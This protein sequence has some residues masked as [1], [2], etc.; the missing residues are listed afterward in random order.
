MKKISS[1]GIQ[2]VDNGWIATFEFIDDDVQK[3]P[4]SFFSM[5]SSNKNS[6]TKI[7]YSLQDLANFLFALEKNN[8]ITKES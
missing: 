2:R 3:E 1:I 4:A 5:F 7:F 8:M 6:V